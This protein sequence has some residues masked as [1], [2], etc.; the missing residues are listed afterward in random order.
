VSDDPELEEFVRAIDE[1]RRDKERLAV[2]NCE[3]RE[4]CE[5]LELD[6]QHAR[7]A[8]LATRRHLNNCLREWSKALDELAFERYG[9]RKVDQPAELAQ[10]NDA[11]GQG[12]SDPQEIPN[13]RPQ[14][15]PGDPGRA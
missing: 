1:L 14:Q 2:Q 12:P 3:L 15:E 7:D 5:R 6:V 11:T 4:K 9:K 13:G 10:N 8:H